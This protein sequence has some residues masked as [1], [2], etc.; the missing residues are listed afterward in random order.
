MS[1]AKEYPFPEE[2][3]AER[4]EWAIGRTSSVALRETLA[5]TFTQRL[6]IKKG[7]HSGLH[8]ESPRRVAIFTRMNART[9]LLID[10]LSRLKL[11][12]LVLSS[13]YQLT[14]TWHVTFSRFAQYCIV[15]AGSVGEQANPVDFCMALREKHAEVPLILTSEKFAV[16]DLTL[17]RSHLCDASLAGNFTVDSLRSV[18]STAASNNLARR[19]ATSLSV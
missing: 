18:L 17:E 3:L 8:F 9:N 5:Q 19:L 7:R 16:D 14:D 15:D 4:A 12:P 10:A 2:N 13:N 6:T 1:K 11:I